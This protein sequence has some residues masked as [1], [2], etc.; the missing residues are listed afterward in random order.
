[1]SRWRR[2]RDVPVDRTE[3]LNDR[4]DEVVKDLATTNETVR[5]QALRLAVHARKLELKE[6]GDG[7]RQQ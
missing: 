3:R 1:M 5:C 4:L 2:H 7:N 6:G